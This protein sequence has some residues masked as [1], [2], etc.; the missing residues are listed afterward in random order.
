MV[1]KFNPK[2]YQTLFR[3]DVDKGRVS[4]MLSDFII[5]GSLGQANPIITF[6][7]KWW[8][9]RLHKKSEI[10]LSKKGLRIFKNKNNYEK[11]TKEFKQYI[12]FADKN[13]VLKYTQ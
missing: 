3:L 1:N 8:T 10:I 12:K 4:G 5:R 9:F 7:G 6:D 11:Y 2:N 13:I